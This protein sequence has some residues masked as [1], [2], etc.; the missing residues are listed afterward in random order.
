MIAAGAIDQ[1]RDGFLVY[2]IQSVFERS[3]EREEKVGQKLV[4]DQVLSGWHTKS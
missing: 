1:P 3:L 2:E 4:A